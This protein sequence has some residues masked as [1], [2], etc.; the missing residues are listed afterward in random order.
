MTY[1]EFQIELIKINLTIKELAT[2]IGMNPNS[3]TNYKSKEIMPLNLAIIV[4]LISSLKNN[5][6]DPELIINEIKRKHS[7]Q[8]LEL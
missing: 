3:I 1:Q 6:L 8:L 5:G 2:L 7:A 4:S